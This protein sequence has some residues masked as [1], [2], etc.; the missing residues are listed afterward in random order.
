[1][2]AE[3]D[4][5]KRRIRIEDARRG[6]LE[7]RVEANAAERAAIA[8]E[9]DL[10]ALDALRLDYVV[11]KLVQGRFRV[12]GRLQARLHQACVVTLGPIEAAIEE[13][14]DLEFWP[15]E[16][17]R[18]LDAEDPARQGDSEWPEPIQGGAMD[19]GR[20]AYETL[21]A[22]LDPY[23]RA[24]GAAFAWDDPA[25]SEGATG[26]FAALKGLKDK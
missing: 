16:Q 24:A 20:I 26:P 6:D 12:R 23:P 9:L 15:A 2:S 3:T 14:V 21:A 25:A 8:D 19:L 5:L 13:P 11:S 10:T 17:I 22:A 18:A 1:M 4:L 7:G